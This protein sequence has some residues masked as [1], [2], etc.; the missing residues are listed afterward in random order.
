M[1]VVLGESAD[2]QQTVKSA[3]PLVSVDGPEFEQSHGKLSIAAGTTSEY[4]AMHRTVHRLRVVG[5][6][7]HLHRWVHAIGVE[8]EMPRCLE[9]VRIGQMRRENELVPTR[10]VPG[11]AV[12][13]HQLA[14]DGALGMPDGKTSAEL[15]G[16]RQE[17]EFDRKSPMIPFLGFVQSMQVIVESSLA[18]PGRSIDSLQG[19]TLFTSSPV[20]RR[21]LLKFEVAQPRSARNIK[22][23]KTLKIFLIKK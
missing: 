11:P 16:E 4:E 6:V 10:L 23:L 9:E 3:G 18:L 8:V 7:V 17:I 13:L 14:N 12:V 15:L 21:H 2:P 22:Y 5:A 20:R 19:G 1:T